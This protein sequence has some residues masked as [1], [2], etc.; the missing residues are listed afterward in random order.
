MSFAIYLIHRMVIG[1]FDVVFNINVITQ[2]LAVFVVI[3]ICYVALFL[4]RWLIKIM[5]L[6]RL[7]NPLFGFRTVAIKK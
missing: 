6:E 1:V 7:L 2:I 3:G 4:C 5:K